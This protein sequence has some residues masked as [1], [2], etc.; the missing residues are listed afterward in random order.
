M[1]LLWRPDPESRSSLR[2]GNVAY[3]LL[4]PVDLYGLWFARAIAGRARTHAAPGGADARPRASSSSGCSPRRRWASFGAWL[5]AT[6]GAL[7]LSGRDHHAPHGLAS[8]G[9]SR[10][11]GSSILVNGRRLGSLGHDRAPPAL[12]GLGAARPRVPAL[13]RPDGHAVPALDRAHP[14]AEVARVPSRTSCVWVV[15]LIALRP[16]ARSHGDAAARGAGRLTRADLRLYLRYVGISLRA[17]ME[18]RASMVMLSLG[19]LLITGIEFFAIW[20]L[21]D[22]FGY[23]RGLV[24]GRGRAALRHGERRLRDLGVGRLA[25]SISFALHVKSGD[26]DRLLLRPRSTALQVAASTLEFT[27]F[28]RLASGAPGA[29]LGRRDPGRSCG[30]FPR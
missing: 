19:Q 2:T 12:A 6:A 25:G 15:A 18:Y 17:Q 10:A 11:A 8:S 21:F 4:R 1:L 28:G 24:P 3:E 16:M 26:F 13:P 23:A 9:R 5:V 7:L 29:R 30:R 27:R 20:A 14:A 22:R